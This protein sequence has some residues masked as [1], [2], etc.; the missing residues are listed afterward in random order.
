VLDRLR[1]AHKFAVRLRESRLLGDV[2]LAAITYA[3]ARLAGQVTGAVVVSPRLA[4]ILGVGI[5]AISA[6]TGLLPVE[7]DCDG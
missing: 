6:S 5:G 7:K 4:F 1:R 3:L 2:G